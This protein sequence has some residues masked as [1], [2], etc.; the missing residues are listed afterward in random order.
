MKYKRR[1][2]RV[3]K[4]IS[5]TESKHRQKSY[6]GASL[7]RRSSWAAALVLVCFCLTRVSPAAGKVVK[8]VFTRSQGVILANSEFLNAAGDYIA[9]FCLDYLKGGADDSDPAQAVAATVK[10]DAAK[11]SSGQDIP[12]DG[13]DDAISAV[14]DVEVKFEPLFPC[15]GEISSEFGER[16]HPISAEVSFHNGIDI[17]LDEGDEVRACFDGEVTKSEYNGSSGNHIIIQHMDGYTSSY[18]HMSKLLVLEGDAVKK[19]DVI[20]HAGSTGSATGPHLH[21]EIRQN[22]TALD[23]ERMIKQSGSN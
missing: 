12:E 8:K 2:A 15:D 23:P 14:T 7:K 11:V 22:G 13:T 5:H 20:G 17:A 18:A 9:G 6:R 16:V 3:S 19:G 1:R 4:Y 10:S 21:F